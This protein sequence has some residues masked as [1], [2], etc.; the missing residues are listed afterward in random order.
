M[1]SD[2]RP[3]KGW[4]GSVLLTP[5]ANVAQH[6]LCECR[7]ASLRDQ[8]LVCTSG[9]TRYRPSLTISRIP[10]SPQFDMGDATRHNQT[11]YCFS[12]VPCMYKVKKIQIRDCAFAMM[13]HIRRLSG[14]AAV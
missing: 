6:R 14:V 1:A 5:S 2:E 9:V 10:I 13:K 8:P 12:S 3:P 11:L 4:R 7:H